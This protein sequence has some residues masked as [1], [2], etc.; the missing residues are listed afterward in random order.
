MK[1][2][3]GKLYYHLNSYEILV[4]KKLSEW[5]NI[6]CVKRMLV[7]EHANSR[8]IDFIP[9]KIPFLFLNESGKDIIKILYEN[10]ILYMHLTAD[11]EKELLLIEI[12][13]TSL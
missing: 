3:I 8:Y 7:I 4:S 9:N 5:K 11:T 6:Y 2:K 13:D 10:K 1:Y 12:N